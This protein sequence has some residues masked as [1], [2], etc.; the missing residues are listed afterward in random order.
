M[1]RCD[2]P[3][4]L[5]EERL[6]PILDAAPR[7]DKLFIILGFETGLRVSELL[8]LRVADVWQTGAPVKT[9]RVERRRLKGGRGLRA[10]SVKNRVIPLNARARSA[11]VDHCESHP[12]TGEYAP[13][14]PSRE[15]VKSVTRR[16]IT[17]IIRKIFLAAGLDP[18]RTWA[19]HS[20]RRR[21][22]TRIYNQTGDIN[23]ARISVGHVWCTTTQA[24]V[25]VDDDAA[26]LEIY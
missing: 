11:L 3:T 19:S 10:S 4:E 13:L 15:G 1:N 21:F 23:L 16:Q 20:L 14:F 2:C 24:Y 9:L 8:G 18:S 26:C 25:G 22:V 6:Q 7:R 12:P 5:D 17:R